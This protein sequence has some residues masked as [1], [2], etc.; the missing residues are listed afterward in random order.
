MKLYFAPGAC[1]LSP[2]IVLREAGLPFSTVKVNTKTKEMDGGG[3]FRTVNS[4]GYV[5][6]LGLDDGTV[7]TEGP[8]DQVLADPRVREVYIGNK[9]Q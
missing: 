7:L 9:A 1:S 6:A 5:P 3:D 4:K 2:H 8:G